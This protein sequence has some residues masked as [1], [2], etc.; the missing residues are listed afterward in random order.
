MAFDPTLVTIHDESYGENDE[1]DYDS[2]TIHVFKHDGEQF[3]RIQSRASSNIS[4]AWGSEHSI[5]DM[6]GKS[7]TV[8]KSKVSGS[9]GSGG[10][11]SEA[12]GSPVVYNL[13]IEYEKTMKKKQDKK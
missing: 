12:Q 8:Q 5:L 3:F 13:K 11:D 9:V 6:D 7:C 10:R 2:Y 4:G 1:G